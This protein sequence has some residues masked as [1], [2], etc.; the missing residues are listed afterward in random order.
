MSCF[1]HVH[2]VLQCHFFQRAAQLSLL[3]GKCHD[4]E[5]DDDG[6]D[7]I[8]SSLSIHTQTVLE[9]DSENK[10]NNPK[11]A[12]LLFQV[13]G[14]ESCGVIGIR[15][16]KFFE[17]SH[18][19]PIPAV[20]QD[21]NIETRMERRFEV[22]SDPGRSTLKQPDGFKRT[23]LHSALDAAKSS[24]GAS[25]SHRLANT[26][27]EGY[28]LSEQF[29]HR[30]QKQDYLSYAIAKIKYSPVEIILQ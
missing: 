30:D 22:S 28:S 17:D 4:Y 5:V 13:A 11:T 26:F 23:R 19:R 12:W 7:S 27:R 24:P 10:N 21:S 3:D 8:L 18:L 1:P 20:G 25:A 9:K 15:V 29:Y 16:S 6:P 14:S 2:N